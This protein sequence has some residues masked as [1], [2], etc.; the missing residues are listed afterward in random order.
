M[1]TKEKAILLLK[2]TRARP[3]MYCGCKEAF[4]SRVSSIL[5]VTLDPPYDLKFVN[6]YEKFTPE[7]KYSSEPVDAA[8]AEALV[9]EALTLLK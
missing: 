3:R 8:W 9:D 7:M 4:L 1:T 5:E 2:A 6:F